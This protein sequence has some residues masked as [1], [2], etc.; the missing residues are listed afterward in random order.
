MNSFIDS[1]ILSLLKDQFCD[2]P[3]LG[4]AAATTEA[5]P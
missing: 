4:T 3:P 5:A 2:R 1:V